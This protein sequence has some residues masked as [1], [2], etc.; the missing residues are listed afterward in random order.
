M[1]Q[2]KNKEIWFCRGC[3]NDLSYCTCDPAT[4]PWKDPGIRPWKGLSIFP[5]SELEPGGV[6]FQNSEASHG[7]SGK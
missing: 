4:R 5:K 1:Q 3:H 6:F 2:M 7:E